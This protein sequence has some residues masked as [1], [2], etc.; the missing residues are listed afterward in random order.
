MDPIQSSSHKQHEMQQ[1]QRWQQRLAVACLQV[2][3][4]APR[5][6]TLRY[7]QRALRWDRSSIIN[8]GEQTLAG[9]FIGPSPLALRHSPFAPAALHTQQLSRAAERAALAW[10]FVEAPQRH[11]PQSPKVT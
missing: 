5:G 6:G 7:L 3:S 11:C 10:R 8:V 1:Q 2:L 9:V 4:R